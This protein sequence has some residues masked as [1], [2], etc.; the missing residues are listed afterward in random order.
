MSHR[1]TE[2]LHVENLQLHHPSL[3]LPIRNGSV[4][5][6][7]PRDPSIFN[8]DESHIILTDRKGCHTGMT[9]DWRR[10]GRPDLT[11]IL[12]AGTRREDVKDALSESGFSDVGYEYSKWSTNDQGVSTIDVG[13]LG[14]E[15]RICHLTSTNLGRGAGVDVAA[16]LDQ[17]QAALAQFSYNVDESPDS[18][19]IL[20]QAHHPS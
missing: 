3:S 20:V 5:F 17:G 6:T 4:L 15:Q 10:F 11:V 18:R 19:K 9:G 2:V 7:L 16:I 12:P 13:P 8:S 14:D 1:S